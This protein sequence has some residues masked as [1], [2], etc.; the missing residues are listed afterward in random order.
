[1]H[2]QEG[3]P[4]GYFGNHVGAEGAGVAYLFVEACLSGLYVAT[5]LDVEAGCQRED[6]GNLQDRDGA[7]IDELG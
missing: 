5:G 2:G 6:Y 1:M 3:A 4:D 7:N